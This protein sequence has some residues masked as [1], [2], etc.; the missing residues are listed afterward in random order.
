MKSPMSAA[1]HLVAVNAFAVF[2]FSAGC[3]SDSNNA[4]T[5][6]APTTTASI[7][8]GTIYQTIDGFG[9]STGYV[10]QN[11]NMTSAQAASYFS[12]TSGIGLSWI[13][14][15]DCGS[16]A[17]GDCPQ[18][19]TAYTPDLPTL[20]YAVQNGAQVLITFAWASGDPS[21]WLS[22]AAYA[23]SKLQYLAA[24]GVPVA[25]VS[26]DNEPDGTG[27]TS[28]ELDGFIKVLVP[29]LSA[30]GLTPKIAM[31]EYGYQF[32]S[33]FY[34]DC[35]TDSTCAG[36]VSYAAEHGYVAY[37][38]LFNTTPYTAAPSA[39]GTRH[40]W[41][42]EINAGLNVAYTCAVATGPLP[43][44]DPSIA[45]GIAW[46]WNI[47]SFLTSGG[48]SLWMYWNLVSGYNPPTGCNDGLAGYTF[49][50]AKRFYVL[51]NWSLFVRPGMV[52][53][54]ATNNPQSGVYVTAFLNQS[55]GALAIVAVNQNPGSTTQTFL[56]S[57]TSPSALTPYITDGGSN[58]LA[59]QTPIAVSG[60]SFT[61]SLNPTSV[62]TFYWQ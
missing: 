21:Q 10:E 57:G 29:A 33:D 1:F 44:Y 23:V 48:G 13:R 24:N 55:T 39:L 6:P 58:N 50:P 30:A 14:I 17:N 7:N 31:P 38:E 40:V 52:M 51:G 11:Q 26:P 36:Y 28:A 62:T 25:V 27:W 32:N 8:A 41:Q 60:N 3:S 35:M 46:A 56:L 12:T 45:D 9:A 53:V 4:I 19:G 16:V 20:Q 54:G 5:T 15:Q 37:P 2:L 49:V 61:Y 59:A 18:P 22:D 43:V 42:T 47:N 34:S